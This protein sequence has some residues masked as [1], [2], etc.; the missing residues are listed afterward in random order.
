LPF[1]AGLLSGTEAPNR[2]C[3]S[4]FDLCCFNG[5]QIR[6]CHTLEGLMR[7]QATERLLR[8][9]FQP[10]P[11]IIPIHCFVILA[12]KNRPEAVLGECQTVYRRFWKNFLIRHLMYA[13]HSFRWI[14]IAFPFDKDCDN[15]EQETNT[16][17]CQ[18]ARYQATDAE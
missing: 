14:F 4:D 16:Q 7:T 9:L 17:H 10:M 12:Q 2:A 6:R 18:V 8:S 15:C 3:R 5:T 1:L 11:S 13:S